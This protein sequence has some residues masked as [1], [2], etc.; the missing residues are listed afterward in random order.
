[1]QIKLDALEAES[2][3]SGTVRDGLD[4]ALLVDGLQAE[5]EQGITIDVAY[6]YFSTPQRK[7]IIADTPGHVEYTRNMATGASNCDLAVIL[8]DARAGLQTQTCRHTFIATLLGIKHLIVAVNKMDLVGY[9]EE[10]F[11]KIRSDYSDFSIK[12]D[13]QDIRY[14]PISAL[15]GDNVVKQSANMPWYRNRPLM[16][17]LE[18]IQISSDRNVNDFRFPV[19]YVNRPNPDFRGYSGTVSSG[20]VRT[21][22][23]VLVMPSR[24]TS[25]VKS[26]STYDGD[27]PKAF[28]PQAV[29]LTLEDDI[30]ISRGDMMVHPDN[31]PHFSS[32]LEADVVWMSEEPMLPGK[33]YLF[34]QVARKTSGHISSLRFRMDVDTLEKR[35]A[36]HYR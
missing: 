8:I 27:L 25:R 28:P 21:G 35:P 29:T 26:L 23:D 31:L 7:F 5:R 33:Q 2:A 24:K 22:D 1:M 20:V 9:S 17:M 32:R 12:L 34:K 36:P 13:V 10:V 15:K 3:K 11:E 30:D 16:E 14:L 18:N 6:R 4:L 19:Q